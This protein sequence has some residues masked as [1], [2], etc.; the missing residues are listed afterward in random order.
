MGFNRRKMED[1]RRQA[2]DKETAA[3]RATDAL[4]LEDAGRLICGLERAPSQAHAHDILADDRR[5]DCSPLLVSVGALPGLPFD[6]QYRP[7]PSRSAGCRERASPTKCVK[8]TGGGCLASE[9]AGPAPACPGTTQ[10][11]VGLRQ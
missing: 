8:S 10:R 3:R 5:R 6:G 4:V 7:T 9:G 11:P 2:S 1:Q